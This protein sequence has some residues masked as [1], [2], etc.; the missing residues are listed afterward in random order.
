VLYAGPQYTAQGVIQIVNVPT[1]QNLMASTAVPINLGICVKSKRVRDFD[2]V[3][4][5]RG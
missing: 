4:N 1:A 2:D 3:L 5:P